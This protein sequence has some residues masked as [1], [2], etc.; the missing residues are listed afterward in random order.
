M[1]SFS[2]FVSSLCIIDLVNKIKIYTKLIK[3]FHFE[4]SFSSSFKML[5]KYVIILEN[6]TWI[7]IFIIA[8]RKKWCE[9][10]FLYSKIFNTIF[11]LTHMSF[12]DSLILRIYCNINK[13][14]ILRKKNFTEKFKKKFCYLTKVNLHTK[15]SR[16]K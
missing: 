13:S 4:I 6:I 3:F 9:Y 15:M 11:Q 12:A 14:T 7:N 1:M 5:S 10:V 16:I 2:I 8:R